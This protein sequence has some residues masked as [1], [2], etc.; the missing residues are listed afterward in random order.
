[1]LGWI[2]KVEMDVV[3]RVLFLLDDC[4]WLLWWLARM[5]VMIVEGGRGWC[6]RDRE[7]TGHIGDEGLLLNR[8]STM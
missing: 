1:M 7:Y 8:T 5:M 4:P 6:V 2:L 3:T